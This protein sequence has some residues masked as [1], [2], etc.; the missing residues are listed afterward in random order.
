MNDINSVVLIGNLTRDCGSQERDFSFN[1]NGTAV[2]NI[3]I[4]CNRSRK[5]GEEYV[6]DVS[7]FNVT[8]FGKTAENL[9]PYLKKGQKVGISGYLK[10][11]RWTDK[12]GNNQS[13]VKVV[14]ETV[15]LC[16]GK[17]EGNTVQTQS[18]PAQSESTGFVEDIPYEE[19]EGHI[20]F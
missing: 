11:D 6:T 1:A 14:A 4:A 2:A 19:S 15:E 18:V 3:S 9:K 17:K 12:N 16:G 10:Q 20:P 7:Y 8:I 13:S 5:Q